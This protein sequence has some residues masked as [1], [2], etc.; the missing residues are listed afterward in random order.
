MS[1]RGFTSSGT[2]EEPGLPEDTEHEDRLTRRVLLTRTAGAAAG[3]AL[4]QPAVAA[5]A[6]ASSE[7]KGGT[8]VYGM[9]LADIPSLDGN[10]ALAAGG[11]GLRVT[12]NMFEALT[13]YDLHVADREPP[14]GPG[15]AESWKISNDGKTWT[16]RLRDGV[17]FHDGTPFNADAAIWNLRRLYDKKSP[18][19][20]QTAASLST[21]W[22]PGPILGL[23]KVNGLT[24]RVHFARSRPIVEEFAN[25]LM[26][27]PTA[28]QKLGNERF[29]VE[30]VGTG[31]FEFKQLVKGQKV[32]MVPYSGYW[33]EK[34]KLDRLI[35]RPIPDP[36]ARVAALRAR[37][38]N[39]I[40]VLPPDAVQSLRNA[41]FKVLLKSYPHSWVYHFNMQKK[42]YT[43]RRVRQALNYALDKE[44][45]MR[46]VLKRTAIP[47]YEVATPGSPF[48]DT[49]IGEKYKYDPDKAKKLLAAAGLPG[50]FSDTWWVPVNGSGEMI[51]VPMSEF[52][53]SNLREVGVKIN[54]KTFEWTAYLGEFFK[55]IR[56]EIG[57]YQQSWGLWGSTWWGYLFGTIGIPPRGIAN[58]GRYRNPQVDRIYDLAL[59]QRESKNRIALVKKIQGIVMEDA[60]WLFVA[61]DLNSKALSPKVH[62]FINTHH[63]WFAFD[64]VTVA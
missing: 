9:E 34:A 33:G 1:T 55:G 27:S 8:L 37:E 57:A 17:R 4:A 7:T 31:P 61:H 11:A 47:A 60:P 44:T 36:S 22:F 35:M 20:Y 59:S 46:D 42:P 50:G 21:I 5:W 51:P 63:W 54:L 14:I 48:F 58:V 49:A 43:D 16:F 18:Q 30:P 23:E 39:M 62:G 6:R 10:V 32:E 41:G 25:L 56:P 12:R 64:T 45:M 53:Q 19:Y 24:F 26:V 38:A 15:L 13:A 3:L 40:I 28:V 2:E 52:I 29:A